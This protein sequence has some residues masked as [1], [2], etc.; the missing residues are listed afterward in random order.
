[1]DASS[2]PSTSLRFTDVNINYI[3]HSVWRLQIIK[4]RSCLADKQDKRKPLGF[5]FPLCI[6]EKGFQKLS[7]LSTSTFFFRE[8]F[9]FIPFYG[10]LGDYNGVFVL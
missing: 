6:A 8:I 9:F 5:L 4:T 10:L 1:M 2:L 3:P 7:V